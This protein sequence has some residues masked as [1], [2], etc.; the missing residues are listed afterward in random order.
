MR[1][2]MADGT[3]KETSTRACILETKIVLYARAI[4]VSRIRG[5]YPQEIQ[6]TTRVPFEKKRCAFRVGLFFRPSSGAREIIYNW[7]SLD[8]SDSKSKDYLEDILMEYKRVKWNE[9]CS[10]LL[11]NRQENTV[12]IWEAYI[13]ND[14]IIN[15]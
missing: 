1:I 14:D 10:V 5:L 6:S 3:W 11:I 9:S 12:T 8:L 2:M 13:L 7:T 4:L 15:S